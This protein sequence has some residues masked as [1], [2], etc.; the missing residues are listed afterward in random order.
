MKRYVMHV[1]VKLIEVNEPE[2]IE[3][4]IEKRHG[5]E[6]PLTT[7]SSMMTKVANGI[8]AAPAIPFPAI[9]F[10]QPG[11]ID[12]RRS[13]MITAGSVQTITK[14]IEQFEELTNEISLE[15]V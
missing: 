9:P 4:P 15:R 11:G 13:A 2:P 6:N 7:I 8:M 10:S 5:D 12:W 1:E 3:E 14:I